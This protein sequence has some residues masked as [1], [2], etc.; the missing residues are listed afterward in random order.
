MRKMGGDST[1]VDVKGSID[2][3]GTPYWKK[4]ASKISDYQIHGYRT[5]TWIVTAVYGTA[6][7]WFRH[8]G[9]LNSCTW[10]N[11]GYQASQLIFGLGARSKNEFAVM[12][13]TTYIATEE[14]DSISIYTR[15]LYLSFDN[16]QDSLSRAT[17][18]GI[19]L[20]MARLSDDLFK[21][22]IP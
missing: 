15:F 1:L 8:L 21:I 9:I 2:A 10:M 13:R 3:Y 17:S 6:M 12:H 5:T 7:I 22:P 16:E 18:N 19:V 14:E 11:C 20:Y 4:D